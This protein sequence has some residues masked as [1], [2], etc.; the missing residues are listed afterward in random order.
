LTI[1]S[2]AS[3]PSWC[4]AICALRSHCSRSAPGEGATGEQFAFKLEVQFAAALSVSNPTQKA[5]FRI[6]R[7]SAQLVL[8]DFRAAVALVRAAL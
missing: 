4:F 8:S 6:F 3:T 5:W 7:V 2:S 1:A